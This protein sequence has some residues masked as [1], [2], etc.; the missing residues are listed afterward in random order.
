MVWC[1]LFQIFLFLFTSP[2]LKLLA[3]ALC[4]VFKPENWTEKKS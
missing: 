3:G 2:L 4:L 1:D